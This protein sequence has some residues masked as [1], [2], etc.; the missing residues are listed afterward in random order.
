[1]GGAFDDRLTKARPLGAGAVGEGAVRIG[2]GVV[3]ER[4]APVD[5]AVVGEPTER[6]SV[7]A[8]RGGVRGRVRRHGIAA[9][10]AMPEQGH[11]AIEDMATAI[12][13]L[14]RGIEP[15]LDARP[16]PVLGN[17]TWNVGTIR[18]GAGVNVVPDLCEIE[19]DRRLVPGDTSAEVLHHVD[20][21]LDDLRAQ[22]SA[23]RIDRDPPFVDIPPLE[24]PHDARVVRAAQRAV[25][26]A[27]LSPDPL[28]VAYAT[29]AAMLSGVGGIPSVVLGPGDIAQAH[30][31][32]EWIEIAQLEQAVGVYLGVCKAFGEIAA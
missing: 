27:G 19:I 13:A 14:A 29:D 3:A 6:R 5:A 4:R 26:A 12:P 15:H 10:R 31:N 21:A 11:N 23:I 30:T 7:T 18:G 2:W 25:A 1:V 20:A 28:G 24:T 32:D 16:H 17:A 22:H 8:Q 9:Q